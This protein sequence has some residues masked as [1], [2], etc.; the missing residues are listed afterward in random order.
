MLHA[1]QQPT[2]SSPSPTSPSFAGLLA[3]LAS[4]AQTTGDFRGKPSSIRRK[5]TSAWN[6][7]DL[8]DDVAT[9]SY[10]S[11]LKVHSATGAS[12]RCVP[13]TS[14]YRKSATGIQP[15]SASAS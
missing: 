12:H 4:P 3:A 1:M 2:A 6:D 8:A 10:E 7:D 15:S 11:A 14:R 5:S 9:L 13:R